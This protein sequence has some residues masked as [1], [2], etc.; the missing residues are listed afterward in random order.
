MTISV[1]IEVFCKEEW[2]LGRGHRVASDH[3]LQSETHDS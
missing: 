2:V 1:M 3:G